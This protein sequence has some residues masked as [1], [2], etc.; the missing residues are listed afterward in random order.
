MRTGAPLALAIAL[1][2]CSSEPGYAAS[3][4]T[5]VRAPDGALWL[6]SPDDDAV[7]TV[8]PDTLEEIGRVRVEGA[9]EQLA[10]AGSTL[11]VTLGLAAEVAL[12]EDGAVTRVAVPCGGTGAVVADGRD[13]VLVTCPHDDL[14][15]RIEDGA[16]DW[17]MPSPGR[18]TSI[19]VSG[20]R[21]AVTASRTGRLRVHALADRA[22]LRED[23][24][25]PEAGFAATSV[26][27][28]AAHGGDFVTAFSRVDHDSDRARPPEDGGYGSV[29]DGSPRIEP[30][31]AGSCG[32]RYAVYDG[33]PRVFSGPSALASAGDS[34]FVVHR[35][36][37]DVALLRCDETELLP[38]RGTFTLGRGPRGI[39]VDGETAWVDV[40]F[41]HA[42]ARVEPGRDGEV[43][44]AALERTREVGPARLSEEA[45]R[46]RIAFYD[47]DDTHLTPSGIVTCGTCHPGGGEDGLSWFFHTE[48]VAPKLR[49]TPPAWG[50]R[51]ELVPF[52][53]DGEFDDGGELSRTTI[54]ELM[55][56]DGLFVD[57]EAIA[58]YMAEVSPPPGRPAADP[59]LA[60]RG[61]ELFAARCA[62]CHGGPLLADGEAHAV[63]APSA[64]PA[65]RLE[66]AY[67]PPLRGV[68]ARPPYLHDGRAPT[69]R[70]VLVDHN[71]DDAHGRTSDLAP[72]DLDALVAHLETL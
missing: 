51:A 1:A 24:L 41:A 19:A 59:A 14:V 72:E 23:V 65:G 5:I 35:S 62:E 67:T 7:V 44:E 46:G 21:F 66:R 2:A 28:V 30:R 20:D 56:G 38:R 69:L 8:D 12:V 54:R 58:A 43:T 10:F 32:G 17:T 60:A 48:N 22:L 42:V 47:A 53:W 16:I 57:T 29:F 50:A 13:G 40:G 11:V 25:V 3:A 37:H 26:D 33:G 9:P 45:M 64:D 34:L 71:P 15:L 39:V 27:A 52:H 18:P 49:R 63:L 70:A 31:L 55:E 68:R 36:T 4:S 6:T 61:A